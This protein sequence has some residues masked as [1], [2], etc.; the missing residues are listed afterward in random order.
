MHPGPPTTHAT[1]APTPEISDGLAAAA[2]TA[3]YAPSI[4]NTQPWLWRT[5]FDTLDLHLRRD[6]VLPVTD[7]DA[8]LATISCGAALHHARTALAAAGWRVTVARLPDATDRDHLA[9][10][11]VYAPAPPDPV[12]ADL[13]RTIPL[14]HTNRQPVTGPPVGPEE[15]AAITAAVQ[16][17]GAMLHILPADQVIELAAAADLAQRVEAGE[18]AWQAELDYW[19][20]G[21]RPAGT[22]IPD[23]AIPQHAPRTTVPGRDFGHGGDQPIS[24]EHDRTAAFAILFGRGDEPRDWLRA[25]EA[26][27]AGWLTA[28]GRGV[29]VMPLSAPVEVVG[30]RETMSRL[31]SYLSSPYLVLRLG[32]V[33]PADVDPPHAPRLPT[34][35]IIERL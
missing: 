30:T 20:G 29:S 28:T 1:P 8:R 18:S 4:H 2:A 34:D 33:D 16:A 12:A 31:L 21:T 13:V 3:G 17:E 19:T 32:T 27:S 11:R 15:L 25:G 5:S 7:P 26:L 24:A 22:G 14:R 23:A 35:Q 9:R 10:L 6:R